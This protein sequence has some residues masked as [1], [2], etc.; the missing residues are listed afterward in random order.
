MIKNKNK[1]KKSIFSINVFFQEILKLTPD[2]HPER[3]NLEMAVEKMLEACSEVNER[4]REH[5]EIEKQNVQ[6]RL[7]IH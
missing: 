5:E 3:V 4:K 7:F 2:D 6:V 1:N